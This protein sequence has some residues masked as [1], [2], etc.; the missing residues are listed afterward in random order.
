MVHTIME[1]NMKEIKVKKYLIM[2]AI[3]FILIALDFHVYTGISYP[4][5]YA[6]SKN[7]IGEVQYYTLASTYGA[8]CT[9]KMVDAGSSEDETSATEST[10]VASQ[11]VKVIDKV[12]FKNIRI[13]IFNDFVGFLLIGFACL[14]LGKARHKF[15][16]AAM[17][18]AFGFILNGILAL[19]PFIFNG[20]LLCNVTLAIGFTYLA[21]NLITIFIFVNALMSM[22]GD[23][24]CRDERKWGKTCWF[25]TFVL[26]ILTTFIFWLGADLKM[27]YNL[28]WFFEIVLVFVIIIFW[29]IM[30][31]TE[32]Y[33]QA[34]YDEVVAKKNK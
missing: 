8:R 16:L 29:A 11:Y 13:D 4:N 28:G 6:N 32:D 22:C 21:C 33:I 10:A 34:S 18:A 20:L 5:Q 15:R 9:Y 26:Q 17:C 31:R 3:G 2:L 19:L 30:R 23:V 25:I 27:L 24:C 14:K 12:F 7:V 1:D